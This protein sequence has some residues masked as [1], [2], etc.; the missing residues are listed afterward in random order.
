MYINKS[1]NYLVNP[2]IKFK[3][4]SDR[5]MKII[6]ILILIIEKLIKIF[7]KSKDVLQY[8]MSFYLKFT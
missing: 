6:I 8:N 3:S 1:L 5:N 4:D 2:T 7:H